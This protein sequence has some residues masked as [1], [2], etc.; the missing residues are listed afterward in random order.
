MTREGFKKMGG[1]SLGFLLGNKVYEGRNCNTMFVL[2]T[3]TYRGRVCT[4]CVDNHFAPKTKRLFF[5]IVTV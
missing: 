2:S 5:L 4:F 1:K 3:I